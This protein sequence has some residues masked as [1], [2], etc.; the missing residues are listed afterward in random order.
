MYNLHVLLDYKL[1][2]II[3]LEYRL[4]TYEIT[5]ITSFQRNLKKKKKKS[6]LF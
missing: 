2:Y 6:W 1:D 4:E 5:K 3:L